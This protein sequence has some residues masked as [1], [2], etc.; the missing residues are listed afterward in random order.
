M[1]GVAILLGLWTMERQAVAQALAMVWNADPPKGCPFEKSADFGRLALSTR[2]AQYTNAGTWFPS[3]ASDG[4]LYSPWTD[5]YILEGSHGRQQNPFDTSE[6]AYSC[7][8]C[9]SR[10]LKAAT[11]QAVIFGSDPLN[12]AIRNIAPRVEASPAPFVGRYPCGSLVLNGV[13]YYGTYLLGN[14]STSDC[15]GISLSRMGPFMGFR[16]SQDLGKSWHQSPCTPANP[17]FPENADHAPVK[18]GSPHFVDFGQN[19]RHSPDGYAYL[20]AH[21]ATHPRAWNNWVQGDQIFLLRVKP[22]IA[23]IDDPHAYEFYA[24]HD[25]VGRQRWTDRFADIQPLLEWEDHL[26]CVTASYNPGLKKYIMCIGRSVGAQHAD[27]LFL[28]SAKLTGP[29]KLLG[30]AQGFGPNAFFLNIPT[31]FIRP[32]GN[33]FWLCYSANFSN[34]LEKGGQPDGSHYA[35][36]LRELLLH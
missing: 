31:K 24:G 15:G 20:L 33:A 18:I 10:S 8:S 21:G 16:W 3:W 19:M 2:H 12:L 1:T 25:A 30:C 22:S 7:V 14:D 13:W 6:P 29:W 32:D 5:G 4:N 34:H 11:A 9:D 23:T 28:E 27:V 36:C 17:L 35:L 26:G